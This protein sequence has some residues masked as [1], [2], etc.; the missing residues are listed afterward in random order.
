M[1]QYQLSET[2]GETEKYFS[3][4][5]KKWLPKYDNLQEARMAETCRVIGYKS[6]WG[7]LPD[8]KCPYPQSCHQISQ[9]LLIW[10]Y[11]FRLNP[12]ITYHLSIKAINHEYR[13]EV[14][15]LT[16]IV[17][18]CALAAYLIIEFKKDGHIEEEAKH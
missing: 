2:R 10:P 11:E 12:D 9:L 6:N 13:N 3:D 16:P 7:P 4:L 14:F 15:D 17:F 8:F 1:N 18:Q 5:A